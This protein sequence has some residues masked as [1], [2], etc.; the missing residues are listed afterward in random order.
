M[1]Q[2]TQM[3]PFEELAPHVDSR[4]RWNEGIASMAWGQGEGSGSPAGENWTLCMRRGLAK[5]EHDRVDIALPAGACYVI[6]RAAQGRTQHCLAA[7]VAH[8]RCACCW[9]HGVQTDRDGLVT[10]Q[11]ITIRVTSYSTR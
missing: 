3:R 8:Q 5:S 2:F 9:R 6:T 11:S 10:R 1:M 4:D 7:K